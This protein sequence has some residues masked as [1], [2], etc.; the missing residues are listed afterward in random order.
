MSE[1]DPT[2]YV[3]PRGTL[4]IFEGGSL[5]VLGERGTEA[6]FPHED[7]AAFLQHLEALLLPANQTADSRRPKER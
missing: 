6:A 3:A 1:D 4:F 7:L 2:R 5:R